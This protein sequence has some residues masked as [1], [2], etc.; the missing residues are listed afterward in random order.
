MYAGM[1]ATASCKHAIATYKICSKWVMY[2]KRQQKH[3]K[4]HEGTEQAVIGADAVPAAATEL[5]G[6]DAET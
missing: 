2:L 1:K 6:T 5:D 3:Q 4:Q